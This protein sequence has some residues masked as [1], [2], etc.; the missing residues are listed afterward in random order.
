MLSLEGLPL[1]CSIGSF[2]RGIMSGTSHPC[3][4][5]AYRTNRGQ[6]QPFC[7][8]IPT[9]QGCLT[10]PSTLQW[11]EWRCIV[12]HDPN[13][14]KN[15]IVHKIG[16]THA[17]YLEDAAWK[18]AAPSSV[19]CRPIGWCE[20]FH[21]S[22]SHK[23]DP[24]WDSR[25]S[26]FSQTNRH[27]DP[28]PFC[29]HPCASC[30]RFVPL[31]LPRH[32]SSRTDAT[33]ATHMCFRPLLPPRPW[34]WSRRDR[35][36]LLY[37]HATSSCYPS[38]IRWDSSS[39]PTLS[40]NEVRSCF[41]PVGKGGRGATPEVFHGG[42]GETLTWTRGVSSR[43]VFG[44]KM[45]DSAH[46]G[47]LIYALVARE[48]TVLAEYTAFTGNFAA[49]AAQCLEKC[50]SQDAKLTYRCDGHTFN[51]LIEDGLSC[52]HAAIECAG[53]NRETRREVDGSRTNRWNEKRTAP[54]GK[55]GKNLG[56][57]LLTDDPTLR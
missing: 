25:R 50:P 18:S 23:Y 51:F 47:R 17:R 21:V 34:P 32:P 3:M 55:R 29:L 6:Q 11:K 15:V 49:V 45:A 37:V 12:W 1:S 54:N 19:L 48:R 27:A 26:S 14:N 16:C 13:V 46:G 10:L 38:W 42:V 22:P 33:T 43:R 52:V 8:M 44:A 24:G 53:G 9:V 36:T 39:S 5:A 7:S 20:G 35:I 4:K 30:A 57:E 40:R 41:I 56:T 28:F 31:R 2:E